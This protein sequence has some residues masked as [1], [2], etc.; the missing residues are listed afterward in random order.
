[1]KRY[2]SLLVI[3]ILSQSHVVEPST[4]L[5]RPV[6]ELISR[7]SS[8]SVPCDFGNI[9]SGHV[10]LEKSSEGSL[11]TLV[12]VL[13]NGTTTI[14]IGVSLNGDD[15]QHS[16]EAMSSVMF[17]CG[18]CDCSTDLPPLD[19]GEIYKVSSSLLPRSI[20]RENEL[21]RFLDQA[22][23]GV[24]RADLQNFDDSD[25]TDV[26]IAKWIKS[27]V[28]D[29]GMT[30]H[31]AW[32]RKR[33]IH[34]FPEPIKIMRPRNICEVNNKWR[35][36]TFSSNDR[37][38]Y[39]LLKKINGKVTISID[40]TIRT[41]V[42]SIDWDE[43]Y[44][45]EY[46][47]MKTSNK[48]YQICRAKNCLACEVR[49][50]DPETG[51]CREIQVDGVLG[52]PQ[53]YFDSNIAMPDN[54]LQLSDEYVLPTR[55]VFF[56][57][58]NPQ[59]L[60]VVKQLDNPLC[61]SSEF[62]TEPVF[63][64]HTIS[65]TY[66]INNPPPVLLDNDIESPSMDGGGSSVTL[67]NG[68]TLCANAKRTPFNEDSCK[69]SNNDGVCNFDDDTIEIT[70]NDDS[71]RTFY[72][73]S[74]S[75]PDNDVRY[76]YYVDGLFI[77]SKSRTS[78]PCVFDR[79]TRWV[80]VPASTS[81]CSN[82]LNT[83]TNE[84]LASLILN[85]NDM[86][87]YII[88]I[89]TPISDGCH[90]DDLYQK[91]FEI[92]VNGTCWQH[93]H[94]HHFNVYD[95]T[96]AVNE[97]EFLKE[98]AEK[99]EVI[100]HY[101]AELSSG[102]WHQI[103]NK[104]GKIGRYGDVISFV[105]LKK[106]ELETDYIEDAF[107]HK[108]PS[109]SGAVVCGSPG[110]VANEPILGGVA[111]DF[112]H[113][114]RKTSD[115]D[116]INT[117]KTIMAMI[118]LYATDQLRQ[119]MAWALAQI[120]T[121]ASP[122]IN[123]LIETERRVAYTDIFVRNAFKSYRNILKEISFSPL[124][125][126]NLSYLDTQSTAYNWIT[127]KQ[128][129]FPAENYAREL[130]QL[131]SVGLCMLNLDGSE[132]KMNDGA[133]VPVYTNNEI[134]EYSR[135][136]TG[137]KAQGLRGNIEIQLDYEY[138]NYLDP[139]EIV[140]EWRDPFP[141]MGLNGKYIGD[142]YP[143]CVDRPQYHFLRKNAKYRLL[144]S[145]SN[146][147]L[148]TDYI[149]WKNN[150][151]VIRM[152]LN[153]P[154]NYEA[155]LYT[156]LCD[157]S[158]DGSCN[159]KSVVV[160][161]SDLAC[162]MNECDVDTVRVVEVT[163]GMFYEYVSQP[164]VEQAFFHDAKK[165]I[166]QT[167]RFP[168]TSVPGDIS[169]ADPR[170]EVASTACCPMDNPSSS[171]FA[172]RKEKYWGE[173]MTYSLASK[174]CDSMSYSTCGFP[175]VQDCE[176]SWRN[177]YECSHNPYYWTSASCELKVKVSPDNGKVAIIYNVEDDNTLMAE[178]VQSDTPS[179]F[180]VQWNNNEYPSPANNCGKSSLCDILND[181]CICT[182]TVEE[183]PVFDLMPTRNEV[184]EYL[185]IGAFE[186]SSLA[187]DKNY[188]E[189]DVTVFYF[190][191][192]EKFD[193]SSIFKVVDGFGRERLLK[194]IVS[195]VNI[196]GTSQSFSFRNPPHFLSLTDPEVRDAYYET[197][198]TL[199]HHFYHQNTAPFITKN[200]IQRFGLSNPSPDYIR[201]VSTAFQ[202]GKCSWVSSSGE[203][204]TYGSE[205][206][207]DLGATIACT[208]LDNDARD[209]NLDLNPSHGSLLEQ[210]LKVYKFMRSM[211]IKVNDDKQL[212]R[213]FDKGLTDHIGQDSYE[214]PTVFSYFLPGF[215][216]AGPIKKASLVAPEAQLLTGP[217][218]L[219]QL[220]G[221]FSL[222][223]WGMNGCYDGFFQKDSSCTRDPGDYSNSVGRLNY[224]PTNDTSSEEI[225]NE[226][227]TLLTGGR[228]SDANKQIIKD[229]YDSEFDKYAALMM[230]QQLVVT[231]PEFHTSGAIVE[232]NGE[233][234]PQQP[235]PQPSQEPYKAVIFLMLAG[236]FDSYNMLVPQC[237]PYL[238][239]YKSKRGIIALNDNELSETITVPVENNQ[240]CSEFAIHHKLPIL[241]QMYNQEKL[242]FLANTGSM[243]KKMNN[244][245]YKT[246]TLKL[247]AHDTMQEAAQTLDP[248]SKSPGSG[249][250]G[251]IADA[252]GTSTGTLGN[253]F[254]VGT[255][256]VQDFS[257]A[258]I[259]DNPKT[260][261]QVIV[262]K[263]GAKEFDPYPWRERNQWK[264]VNLQPA[265]DDLNSATTSHS[266][267]FGE[268]W[269]SNFQKVLS[270]NK[271]LDTA[272]SQSQITETF[273]EDEMSKELLQVAKLIQR[274]NIRGV[275]RDLFFLQFGGWDHHSFV[276]SNLSGKFEKLNTAL[277]SFWSEMATQGNEDKVT[278]VIT[279]D[280]GRTLTPNSQDGSDHAWGGN[281]F[282]MGGDVKGGQILGEYP[283][284]YDGHLDAGRGRM[285]PTTPWDS[286]WHGIS[287]WMGINDE[288]T[289]QK[290]I[291]GRQSEI[292][293]NEYFNEDDLF[294]NDG[295]A[296]QS[297]RH[298]LRRPGSRQ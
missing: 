281:Y 257:T 141:K 36:F 234:R 194:N 107:Q 11:C 272:L 223:K 166:R 192:S 42:D 9:G 21:A 46:G 130:L 74:L 6:P 220:N 164:C 280:F 92:N 239:N 290:V 112:A 1:M 131:Y 76:V 89:T 50:R 87:P 238:S 120:V 162:Y 134:S 128:L 174:R 38:K 195:S 242:L 184:L 248:F 132:I 149:R 64:F 135:A 34:H 140:K 273:D 209:V 250:L 266:S 126:E 30:S 258:L 227:S 108:I 193:V 254:K 214:I 262:G 253:L 165:V 173:R 109:L 12:K 144:G 96:D 294:K 151:R 295:I 100:F 66:Y 114:N 217:Y 14:S 98:P 172:V 188:F 169:C 101:P 267:L 208:L 110:E 77:D 152:T 170:R 73:A 146:P 226:L 168:D 88:D 25:P 35:K 288:E 212:V 119:R 179:Y 218:V 136:W 240:P 291:P 145:S 63:G 123:N 142:G 160:L 28:E 161:D 20:S 256:S 3:F 56:S 154:S 48:N 196:V 72:S 198:A 189:N 265:I 115:D 49:L 94:Q 278:L 17:D 186:P 224:Y 245:N 233:S 139:L 61:Q 8:Q 206:Y 97:Q 93:V 59:E 15:W 67:T 22:T 276:K 246:S 284:D 83:K 185:H 219:S 53:I 159:F 182:V 210:I 10:H 7:T 70:L 62:I 153:P 85:T 264:N 259:S 244:T 18:S 293:N 191:N 230:A 199:D 211:E 19:D 78:P 82:S 187:M 23:F 90:N 235:L 84:F 5:N 79:E 54:L 213:F 32:F 252:L 296:S 31:R 261:F 27:Q 45:N 286:V 99:G 270:D 68:V 216:P 150:E 251:R 60:I 133:C 13:S 285:V 58:H 271:L 263:D 158:S 86:N 225:V 241:N 222:I 269:S 205:T 103:D 163:P 43:W 274:S 243:D 106:G 171:M 236:G 282:I 127:K 116:Y 143:L 113:R 104:Y 190:S 197:D 181:S 298:L 121:I 287:Q 138:K 4:L 221:F 249:V 175:H 122:S 203:M 200:L 80:R 292:Q 47:H 167:Y 125:G 231:S 148:Q 29:V 268:H 71:L 91:G 105:D 69:L 52:N 2:L 297:R 57:D 33:A 204:F 277:T 44:I 157:P 55:E 178:H 41:V 51:F 228:L 39:V 232:R 183:V 111:F 247:F 180:P 95:V 129:I 279:S 16:P 81:T 156:K 237:E 26:A 289:L 147:E 275:D 137:F 75:D 255:T 37:D 65:N 40:D 283:S 177:N 102:E 260:P 229:A 207:G 117:R 124:M 24:T 176:Y 155:N 201:R 118:A 202:T 215:Q